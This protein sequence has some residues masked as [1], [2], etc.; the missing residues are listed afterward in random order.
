MYVLDTAQ[1]LL[2]SCSF[3]D[4]KSLMSLELPA[5]HPAP[6]FALYKYLR[7]IA[8]PYNKAGLESVVD[9]LVIHLLTA[10]GFNDGY[11]MVLSKNNLKFSMH[12]ENNVTATAD[13]TVFDINRNFR[14]AVIEV[15]TAPQNHAQHS[16]AQDIHV[17]YVS[18]LWVVGSNDFFVT[19]ISPNLLKQKEILMIPRRSL[20]QR[21]LLPLK[22]IWPF[23]NGARSVA[24]AT[25]HHPTIRQ[26]ESRVELSRDTTIH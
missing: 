1:S 11:F 25:I 13:V 14:L 15:T 8:N 18:A 5:P 4:E 22:P 17:D 23:R 20:W 6:G 16:K 2:D 26:A 12:G 3:I 21:P 9:D 10:L 7:L 19:R 24:L